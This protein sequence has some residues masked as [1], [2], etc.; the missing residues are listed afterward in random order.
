MLKEELKDLLSKKSASN[1]KRVRQ[2]YE[3]VRSYN[4]EVTKELK[5]ARKEK[6]FE[7][8]KKLTKE[9]DIELEIEL[10]NEVQNTVRIEFR[11]TA[12]EVDRSKVANLKNPDKY[13]N[14]LYFNRTT[15]QIQDLIDK[16]EESQ[17]KGLIKLAEKSLDKLSTDRR[18][19]RQVRR[20]LERM[21]EDVDW[22]FEDDE[23]DEG[24]SY[25]VVYTTSGSVVNVTVI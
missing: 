13:I 20:E 14:K 3:E 6:D 24:D 23:P 10:R 11:N 5:Q 1:D 19:E 25:D 16:G 7:T 15:K 2:E 18:K 4:K 21:K 8:I 9:R 12:I 17:A 22:D